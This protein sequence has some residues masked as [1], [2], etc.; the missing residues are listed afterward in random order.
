MVM[1]IK[2]REKVAQLRKKQI[3]DA[4]LKLFDKK[5]FANTTIAEIADLAGIS[6]GLVYKYFDTK[7][8]LLLAYRDIVHQCEKEVYAMPT[9]TESL[10][11]FAARLLL[12]CEVTGYQP[13][14]RVLIMEFINGNLGR[15]EEENYF[16]NRYGQKFFGPLIK[17]GQ[18]AGEFRP[19]NPEEMGDIFWHTL[20]GYTVQI[21]YHHPDI[22][23]RPDIEAILDIVRIKV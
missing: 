6:K 2:K 20:I 16:L 12:E 1:S 4:S 13:P 7:K 19:G 5:G 17:K 8:D 21:M 22:S 9:A 18:D 15:D 11:L 10:R 3:L 14:L 23:D